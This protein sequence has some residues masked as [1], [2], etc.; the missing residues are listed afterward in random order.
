MGQTRTQPYTDRT[1]PSF[2]NFPHVSLQ[3]HY[4]ALGFVSNL[5]IT[6]PSFLRVLEQITETENLG[7]TLIFSL[8]VT[9][10]EIVIVNK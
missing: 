10:N 1:P 6:N 8:N 7:I 3:D 9:T 4:Y 2:I 5:I